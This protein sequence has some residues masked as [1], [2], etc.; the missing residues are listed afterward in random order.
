M[1]PEIRQFS[2][3]DPGRTLCEKRFDKVTHDKIPFD[4][5]A[6]CKWC[7]YKNA[8]AKLE[9]K[10]PPRPNLATTNRSGSHC[11]PL[12]IYKQHWDIYHGIGDDE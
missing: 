6:A 4:Y 1:K 10:L 11:H 8:E 9:G 12:V 5:R 7:K 2:S 3:T